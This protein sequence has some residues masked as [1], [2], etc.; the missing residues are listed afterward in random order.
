LNNKRL[1]TVIEEALRTAPNFNQSPVDLNIWMYNAHSTSGRADA[2]AV[3]L[4]DALKNEQ[5][6]RVFD[7]SSIHVLSFSAHLAQYWNLGAW[8]LARAQSV[9]SNQALEDLSHY[10]STDDVTCEVVVAFC[11]LEPEGRFD[12]G[13]AISFLPWAQLQN[14]RQKQSLLDRTVTSFPFAYPTGA[15]V[16]ELNTKKSYISQTEFQQ[17]IAKY[18][19]DSI[20]TTEI[21]DSLMCL[22]I[23]QPS[24]PQVLASWVS[25]PSW[26]PIAAGPTLFPIVDGISPFNKISTEGCVQGGE[27]F[28]AF[29]SASPSFQARIRLVLQRLIR[30]MRR[31][32]QVD[33]AIDLG[34]SLEALYLNDMKGD[35]GELSFRLRTR[36][37]RFLGNNAEERKRIFR[38]MKD[39][40]NL[41]SV[42][43]HT[44]SVDTFDERPVQD[45]LH[46]G[47]LC[48]AETVRHF[49]LDG[50][51][52]WDKVM[53]D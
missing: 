32:S 2:H 49:I 28:K 5:D 16:R 42:A 33:A 31:G 36:S 13:R 41:R 14:S 30:A 53:F 21:Y 4:L 45:V 17:N 3:Q 10:L 44:G 39:A 25:A 34:I 37:S 47:F 24:S 23:V 8:L 52:D 22:A 6:L 26:V 35:R 9:G 18:T 1:R 51:P 29:C 40:Y 46:D 7:G 50:K 15:L 11:G 12:M 19:I 27:L 38:L 43:V 48:A 20:D